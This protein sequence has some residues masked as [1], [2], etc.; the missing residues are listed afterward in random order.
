[1][2]D[3]VGIL[4]T[5]LNPVLFVDFFDQVWVVGRWFWRRWSCETLVLSTRVG[6]RVLDGGVQPATLKFWGVRTGLVPPLSMNY[7]ISIRLIGNSL[8]LSENICIRGGDIEVPLVGPNTVDETITT[9][10]A[11]CSFF[12]LCGRVI[13][14]A[15]KLTHP[16]QPVNPSTIQGKFEAIR[17]ISDAVLCEKDEL[18]SRLSE[19]PYHCSS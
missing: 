19:I 17:I 2:G 18:T 9:T 12:S 6:S 10:G 1:V 14:H 13:I 7:L 16:S 4:G 3:H 8:G 11:F 15:C 5:E